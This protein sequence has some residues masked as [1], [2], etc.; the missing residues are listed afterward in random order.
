MRVLLDEDLPT[1]LAR[2]LPPH[3]VRHVAELGWKGKSNGELLRDAV[4]ARF[5]VLL[6]GDAHMPFQQDL[7]QHDIAVV[8]VR[9]ERLVLWRL[10]P[11]APQL[12]AAIETAPRRMLSIVPPPPA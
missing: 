7:R 4:A 11:L 3:E 12:V 1:G 2:H 8:Q 9:V 10:I 6:T 5:D